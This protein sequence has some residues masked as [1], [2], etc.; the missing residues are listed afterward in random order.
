MGGFPSP[1]KRDNL[2]H[3]TIYFPLFQKPAIFSPTHPTRPPKNLHRP[4]R[5]NERFPFLFQGLE[6]SD[7]LGDRISG[8]C[9]PQY[10]THF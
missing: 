3:G 5:G 10:T 8:L 2:D 4:D 7:Q 1:K 9:S 6:T